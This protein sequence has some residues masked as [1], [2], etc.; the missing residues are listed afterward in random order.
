M[1]FEPNLYDTFL[2]LISYMAG[3]I[4]DRRQ[5]CKLV[6]SSLSFSRVLLHLWDL[7]LFLKLK[8]VENIA[9]LPF[10]FQMILL[11]FSLS[12]L[13]NI[14]KFVKIEVSFVQAKTMMKLDILLTSYLLQDNLLVLNTISDLTALNTSYA[15]ITFSK[16][17]TMN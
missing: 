12:K 1:C 8:I 14:E 17:F 11:L 10:S 6:L 5:V 4:V 16:S 3:I 15:G 13:K 9:S 2:I 7:C